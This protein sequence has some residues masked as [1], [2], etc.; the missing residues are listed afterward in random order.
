MPIRLARAAVSRQS[1]VVRAGPSTTLART[2]KTTS[3]TLRPAAQL[4]ESED[5][6]SYYDNT[7]VSHDQ[8]EPNYRNIES[9]YPTRSPNLIR[10]PQPLPAD[11]TNATDYAQSSMYAASGVLD[12]ISM[13]AICLRRPEHIPRAYQIFQQILLDAKGSPHRLPEAEVWARVLEGITSLG[14]MKPGDDTWK[15]WR[16]RADAM[17]GRWESHNNMPRGQPALQH[18]GLKV[19]QGYLSGLLK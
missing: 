4:A 16:T 5:R 12:S 19:Y 9:D 17:V 3:R 18:D 14:E 6:P 7:P 1:L 13:I 15:T 11:V 8:P 2:L 10:M